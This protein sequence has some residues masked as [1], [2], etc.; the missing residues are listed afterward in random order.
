[1]LQLDTGASVYWHRAREHNVD[2][3][4]LGLQHEANKVVGLLSNGV[5]YKPA[6]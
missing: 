5:T 3:M 1:M 4:R 2:D 6:L